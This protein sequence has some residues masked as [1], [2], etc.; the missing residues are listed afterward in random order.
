[1]GS[2]APDPRMVHSLPMAPASYGDAILENIRATRAR[3][4]LDQRDVSERMR[5]LGYTSWHRQTLGKVERGE[6]RL[7]A[8]EVI[9]LALALGTNTSVLLGGPP[10]DVIELGGIQLSGEEVTSLASG[11]NSRSIVWKGN[12]PSRREV[13]AG[14]AG[15]PDMPGELK[16]ALQAAGDPEAEP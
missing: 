7:A 6:R 3:K 5:N 12:V 10:D 11:R 8:S 1:M 4:K 2:I 14:W 16:D 9:G 13:V 15:D